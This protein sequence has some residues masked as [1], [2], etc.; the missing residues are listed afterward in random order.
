MEFVNEVRLYY[1]YLDM[2]K[3]D[4]P[5]T[6]IAERNGFSNY[7]TFLKT[8]RN[9]LGC[10]PSEFRNMPSAAAAELFQGSVSGNEVK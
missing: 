3:T 8:F 10:T 7:D 4:L 9:R 1:V 5:V 6:R 2:M